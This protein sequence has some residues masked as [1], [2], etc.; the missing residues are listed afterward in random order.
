MNTIF[1]LLLLL[2]FFTLVSSFPDRFTKSRSFDQ[3]S[4]QEEY[5][6]LALPLPSDRLTPGL[7]IPVLQHSFA[8]TINAPPFSTP[9]SPPSDC[10]PPWSFVV[11]ELRAKCRGEQYD[12][13][14]A[15]WLAGVEILRTSTAEPTQCGIFW[16][17]RKDVTRY[18]SLLAQPHLNLTMMLENVVNR[19]YTGVYHV[20]VSLLYYKD[21]V[22]GV[23]NPVKLPAETENPNVIRNSQIDQLL[24]L[25]SPEFDANLGAVTDEG[26][27]N[28]IIPISDSGD[29]GF[30][31]RVESELDLKTREI[32]FPRNTRRAVLEIYVSFHGNDEFWY[33][34]PPNSYVAMNNL[35]TARANGGYREVFVTIDGELVGSEVPF[36]VVFTGGINPLFW[37]PVVAIGAFNLP[38]YDIELTPFLGKLLDRKVHRLGIGVSDVISYWLVNANLHLWLDPKSKSVEAKSSFYRNPVLEIERGFQF[39]KLDGSFKIKAQR[40]IQYVGWVKWSRGNYTTTFTQNYR[41]R[42]SIRFQNNGTLKSVKQKIKANK[43][44]VVRNDIR[45]VVATESVKRKYPLKVITEMQPGSR[46]DTYL[47]RTNVSHSLKEKHFHGGHLRRLH[48]GQESGGWMEVKDHSVISGKGYTN[49][50]FGYRDVFGCYSRIVASKNGKLI[51]DNTTFGCL[52]LSSS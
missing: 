51:R 44:V 6:E 17:V 28:L 31:F 13:I 47:L 18:S 39:R 38:S 32:R 40:A 4:P 3:S 26:P 41:F 29:R 7:T 22:A 12:R 48:N 5:F 23:V 14:A 35:D 8:N 11:V 20:E 45:Q 36:P 25:E 9:Y 33:S 42:S 37:E 43:E 19:D 10:P 2:F 16:K 27:A 30:W 34:N 52:S 24:G 49:Q 46:K 21:N 1:F 50:T 15:L